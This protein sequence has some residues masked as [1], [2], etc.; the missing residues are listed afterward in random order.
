MFGVIGIGRGEGLACIHKPFPQAEADRAVE[1]HILPQRPG[2][3]GKFG[4]LT[5][6]EYNFGDPYRD[7]AVF[8]MD[9]IIEDIFA[10]ELDGYLLLQE[11]RLLETR[12]D[13]DEICEELP[14]LENVRFLSHNNNDPHPAVC[15]LKTLFPIISAPDPIRIL[16]DLDHEAL[17]ARESDTA[18]TLLGSFVATCGPN[19]DF[20]KSHYGCPNPGRGCGQQ[21][22]LQEAIVLL[23]H[24]VSAHDGDSGTPLFGS[25]QPASGRAPSI[26]TIGMLVMS[27]E[28]KSP[29]DNEFQIF[30]PSWTVWQQLCEDKQPRSNTLLVFDAKGAAPPKKSRLQALFN[31]TKAAVK[32]L[33]SKSPE[34]SSSS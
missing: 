34:P 8:R 24:G 30:I 19:N 7:L 2:R 29:G 6:C 1:K 12:S 14:G 15:Q 28:V 20:R 21:I 31:S 11:T 9:G 22:V 32:A 16:P 13:L 4:E 27:S 23:G 5:R 10:P 25:Y 33:L 26:F 18:I 3:T 17:P